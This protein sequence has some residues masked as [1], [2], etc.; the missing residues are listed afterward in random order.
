MYL[1]IKIYII[2]ILKYF[3]IYLGFIQVKAEKFILSTYFS[4]ICTSATVDYQQR[5]DG[6]AEA[7]P[8]M[9]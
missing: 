9:Y 8:K 1:R 2:F 4:S 6:R 7:L 5:K 3:N